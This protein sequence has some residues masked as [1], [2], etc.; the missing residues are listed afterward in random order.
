MKLFG[1][2]VA[3]VAVIGAISIFA[4]QPSG[5]SVATTSGD[6]TMERFSELLSEGTVAAERFETNGFRVLSSQNRELGIDFKPNGQELQMLLIKADG[7]FTVGVEKSRAMSTGGGVGIFHRE[8]G[9]P[10]VSLGDTSGDGRLD[11][12]SYTVVDQQGQAVLDIIDYEADGQA[13]LRLHLGGGTSEIWHNERW[14]DLEQRG[15][16]RGIVVD[17]EFRETRNVDNRLVVQQAKA[18]S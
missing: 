4:S 14:Y 2:T 3:L 7:I 10:M 8:T 13:D 18:G 16:V 17:G 11:I 9:T 15:G 1:G 6:D 5:Q 12:I